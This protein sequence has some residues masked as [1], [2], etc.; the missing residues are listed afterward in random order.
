MYEV[1]KKIIELT[2]EADFL[3]SCMKDQDDFYKNYLKQG[4]LGQMKTETTVNTFRF[5]IVV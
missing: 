5:I 2:E 4:F 1:E 3:L